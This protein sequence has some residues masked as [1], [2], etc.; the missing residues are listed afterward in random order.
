MPTGR[1]N[2]EHF[3][4]QLARGQGSAPFSIGGWYGVPGHDPNPRFRAPHLLMDPAS[5]VEDGR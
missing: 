2:R 4:G 1:M 5:A 3:D